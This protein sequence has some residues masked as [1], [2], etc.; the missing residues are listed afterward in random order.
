MNNGK[1]LA[2]YYERVSTLH[3][4]QSESMENQ[5]QLCESYLRRHPEIEL[6]EPIY[7]FSER[8]SG[9]SDERPKYQKMMQRLSKGDIDFV[10]VKDFK[11]MNRSQE[12]SAQLKNLAKK[13]EFKFILL[14]TGQIYDINAS[15][16][17][18]MYGFE[19][20]INEEV[21][22]RQSE[23][24]RTAHRQKCEAKRLNANNV[25]F[26]YAW[27]ESLKDIAIDEW[28][29]GI[30]RRLF[31]LYVFR[32]YGVKEL[33]KYLAENGLTYSTNTVNKWL[34]ESAYIG[35]FHINKKGSELGV[36]A[37]QKTKR[38][39]N[40]KDEWV[41]VERPD[42][43]IVDKEIFDLAQRIR[44]SRQHYFEPAK[45]GVR[46]GRFKGTHLFSAKIYCNECGCPFVHGY[47]DRNKTRSIYRDSYVTRAKN[48]LEPCSNQEYKRVYEEDM[49]SVAVSAI[50]GI[51]Q[52]HQD[53][54]DL[55]IKAVEEVI[56]DDNM[57]DSIIKSKE[58]ELR[59]LAKSADKILE[60]FEYASGALLADLNT[61][62]NDIKAK[63]DEVESEIASFSNEGRDAEDVKEQIGAIQ[64]AVSNWKSI[65][66]DDL[67]RTTIEAFIYKMVIH[68][69][70]MLEVILNTDKTEMFNLSN[71]LGAGD[72]GDP[73]E[74]PPSPLSDAVEFRY[75]MEQ[76]L[77]RVRSMLVLLL[78]EK[79]GEAQIGVLSFAYE[80]NT[81]N[82]RTGKKLQ[83]EIIVNVFVTRKGG[84][85]E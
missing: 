1:Y 24:G 58:K 76:Y 9:K 42:L 41:A 10:L 38:F 6:A 63:M 85:H 73:K 30:I 31:E 70:G 69:D 55:L 83:F 7:T 48:P 81:G 60:T 80:E 25:T 44:E 3:D 12:V 75:G 17:R 71:L 78:R 45:N 46:Q 40:P 34:Q 37:G 16:N 65:D 57:Q 72:E 67:D 33:R 18:M 47:A 23:Y 77:E 66:K 28:K 35:T 52:E 20:L 19:S 26:G 13:Y 84:F 32:D 53:C 50:N 82:I 8:L 27:D 64:Q 68:K 2:V 74:D 39:T 22:Y 29:A 11:R 21:V 5:R 79:S 56:S 4:E 43:A 36:G 61:K 14:A 49:K 59:Q 15:E 51:I 54:F 62:Y